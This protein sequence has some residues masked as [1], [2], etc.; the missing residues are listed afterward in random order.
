LERDPEAVL[1]DYLDG[2]ITK[3]FAERHYKVIFSDGKL[4]QVLTAR[5]RSQARGETHAHPAS[6]NG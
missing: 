6:A 3:K 5:L 1:E 4:D 2:K